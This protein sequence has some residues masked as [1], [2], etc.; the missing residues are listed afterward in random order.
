MELQEHKI[1][2]YKFVVNENIQHY[3]TDII[4]VKIVDD[5]VGVTFAIKDVENKKAIVSHRVYFTLNHF[6]TF[7]NVCA[8]ASK[9]I[10]ENFN[11]LS[12]LKRKK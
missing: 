12:G 1:E 3:F 9:L 6:L 2:K 4:E 7:S 5:R 11:K 10:E 8:N